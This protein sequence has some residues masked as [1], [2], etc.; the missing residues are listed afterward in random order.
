[1]KKILL[2]SATPFIVLVFC[3]LALLFN[4]TKAE[5]QIELALTPQP[6]EIFKTVFG[7]DP[8][9]YVLWQADVC[10]LS[11]DETVTFHA[12]RMNIAAQKIGIPT[13]SALLVPS[14]VRRAERRSWISIAIKTGRFL[15]ITGSILT[16]SEALRIGKTARA[17]L[18]IMAEFT[19]SAVHDLEQE[20]P[21][22]S[23]V[24]SAFMNGIMELPPGACAEKLMMSGATDI[25]EP[26]IITI[27]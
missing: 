1:M 6:E 10:N 19:E 4:A 12:G 22:T 9:G 26:V 25:R 14:V 24:Q 5:T 3:L 13:V 18:P 11:K 8:N 15:A 20:L 21:D 23:I 27:E 16:A 17:I 7:S 2:E